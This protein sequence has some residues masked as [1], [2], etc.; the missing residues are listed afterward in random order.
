MQSPYLRSVQVVAIAALATACASAP[1]SPGDAPARDAAAPRVMQPGA[2]GQSSRD[3]RQ[4]DLEAIEGAGYT[5]ADVAFMQGMIHHHAQA[6]QM[7]ALIEDRTRDRTMRQMGLRVRISQQ[8]EIGMMQNWLRDRGLSAPDPA[9]GMPLM[10]M[11][12]MQMPG[13]LSAEQMNT[14]RES[15]GVEFERYFL[16]FMIQH[17]GGA[18]VMVQELFNTPGAGQESTIN[19]FANEV[20][21]DQ[22]IEIQRM[23][24][25][26]AERR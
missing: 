5:D 2:P 12:L 15:S 21:S 18:I 25:M 10:D 20:D 11:E 4:A 1:S 8:D 13:M 24:Q 19:F 16:Q 23:Q 17:H 14:L 6:L 22:T 26:L 9:A 7:S 3:F